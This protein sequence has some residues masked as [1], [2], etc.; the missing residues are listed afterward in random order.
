MD[1]VCALAKCLTFFFSFFCIAF[2]SASLCVFS[3]P[4][5]KQS[6]IIF[7]CRCTTISPGNSTRT[8]F[9][10]LSNPTK[11]KELKAAQF[12]CLFAF[13]TSR[14]ETNSNFVLFFFSVLLLW[15]FRR[16]LSFRNTFPIN[17]LVIS[18]SVAGNE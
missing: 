15:P 10:V 3:I 13:R 4:I 18:Q 5:N 9:S 12:K 8:A 6:T 14:S 2:S 7:R 11:E 1:L 17:D 16:L